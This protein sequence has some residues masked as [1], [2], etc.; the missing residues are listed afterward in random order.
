MDSDGRLLGIVV[1]EVVA[2][3][4]LSVSVYVEVDGTR[5]N[6]ANEIGPKALKQCAPALMDM[7]RAQ[8]LEGFAKVHHSG[9]WK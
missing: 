1:L 5:W 7:Y 2:K 9:P 4:P 6:N 8:D 3:Y